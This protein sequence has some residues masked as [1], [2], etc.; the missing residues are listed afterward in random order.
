MG[1]GVSERNHS[2]KSGFPHKRGGEPRPGVFLGHL[3]AMVRDRLSD[4]PFAIPIM[5]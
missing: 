4:L 3:S 1:L 2:N 5:L